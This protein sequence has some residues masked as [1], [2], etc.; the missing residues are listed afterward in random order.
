[1]LRLIENKPRRQRDDAWRRRL[2]R[3]RHRRE[4]LLARSYGIIALVLLAVAAGM[5][6]W[7]PAFLHARLADVGLFGSATTVSKN[8]PLCGS[9]SR[10]T[11]VVDGDT[12]WLDGVKI[13]LSDINTPEVGDPLC[14]AEAALGAKATRRL[15][16]LLN[17]GPFEL[18]RGIRDEDRYG[19][20][21]RMAQ[22]DGRSLGDILVDEGL[23]HRWLGYKQDWCA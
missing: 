5:Y 18:T 8:F 22:R 3:G 13:R 20:K 21:L 16:F 1:M 11:C 2:P 4:S 23:A 10:V 17:A 7:Q 9:G 12:F 15:Q 14:A 19:R 6:L